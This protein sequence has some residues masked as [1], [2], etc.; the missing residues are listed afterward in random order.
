MASSS[1][2]NTDF[3]TIAP[4]LSPQAFDGAID[5][6]LLRIGRSILRGERA[7]PQP[8]RVDQVAGRK[9]GDFIWTAIGPAINKRMKALLD[10]GHV[11]GWRPYEVTV[12]N[13]SGERISEYFGLSVVGRCQSIRI[14]KGDAAVI[15]KSGV[16]ADLP[17]YKGLL[18]DLSTWDGSDIFIAADGETGHICIT[19]NLRDILV[20]AK[21]TGLINTPAPDVTAPALDKPKIMK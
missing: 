19:R 8:V 3:F 9:P 1:T 2:P 14:D 13:L 21:A 4:S 15:Y 20:R 12:Y 10:G 6:D 18:V 5:E 7:P 16:R 17:Y 11:S